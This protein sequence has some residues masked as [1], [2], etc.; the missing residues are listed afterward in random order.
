MELS[1]YTTVIK[2][3]GEL[4]SNPD[5]F[6]L[7][8]V[9]ESINEDFDS[10]KYDLKGGALVKRGELYTYRLTFYEIVQVFDE[11]VDSGAIINLEVSSDEAGWR[12][13]KDKN[14]IIPFKY[15]PSNTITFYSGFCAALWRT[16]I[17]KYFRGITRNKVTLKQIQSRFKKFPMTC[18]EISYLL[19]EL[20]Y[21]LVKTGKG[22]SSY[23][24][25][26]DKVV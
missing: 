1:T 13:F 18:G 22:F 9:M 3:V 23:Y 8:D 2:K 21:T 20:G 14:N 16:S 15:K 10:E 4:R 19:G 24:V 17:E 6:T 7:I 12:R 26:L 5:G 11:L 25:D